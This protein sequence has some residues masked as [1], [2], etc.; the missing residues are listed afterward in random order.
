MLRLL[1]ICDRDKQRTGF[2]SRHCGVSDG[3]TTTT[4]TR[5]AAVCN[6]VS[7]YSGGSGSVELGPIANPKLGNGGSKAQGKRGK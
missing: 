1:T 3:T 7:T 6:L 4:T 2:N 5:G